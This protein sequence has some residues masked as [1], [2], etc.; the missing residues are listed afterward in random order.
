MKRAWIV[1]GLLAIVGACPSCGG[2]SSEAASPGSAENHAA[3]RAAEAWLALLDAG[4]YEET[5]STSATVFR[6]GA[7]SPESWA[8]TAGEM[9]GPLGRMVS[10]HLKQA[11]ASSLQEGAA[12]AFAFETSFEARPSSTEEVT[13]VLDGG[14]WRVAGYLVH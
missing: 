2:S 9:R 6:T 1:C 4:N 5:W 13:V 11:A 12:Y 3:E 7:G 10:R 14:F 8:N